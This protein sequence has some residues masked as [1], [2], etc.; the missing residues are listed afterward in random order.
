MIQFYIQIAAQ[1]LFFG[2]ALYFYI[3]TS[4]KVVTIDGIWSKICNFFIAHMFLLAMIFIGLY[5]YDTIET[6]NTLFAEPIPKFIETKI[7]Q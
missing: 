6:K 7:K 1:V 4:F 3:T 2:V 5:W